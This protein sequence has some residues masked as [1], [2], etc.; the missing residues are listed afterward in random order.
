MKKTIFAMLVSL[1][2]TGCADNAPASQNDLELP[3][4]GSASA[5]IIAETGEISSEP[6][7][8]FDAHIGEM[9]DTISFTKDM[10]DY[11]V[12]VSIDVHEVI[13][14]D[15][16]QLIT[17]ENSVNIRD[18]NGTI[19]SSIS[20]SSPFIAG[21]PTTSRVSDYKAITVEVLELDSGNLLVI[22][23]PIEVDEKT[24]RGLAVFYFDDHFVNYIGTEKNRANFF[25][26]IDG[27]I[28]VD[29]DTFTLN[30]YVGS[31]REKRTV[32]YLVDFENILIKEI[33]E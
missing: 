9:I 33:T 27:D 29:G 6:F 23:T 24:A 19:A 14:S 13:G 7:W 30:E 20:F 32:T 17:D 18:K 16:Y 2:A 21:A 12:N 31:E 8:D 11:S 28:T 22:G 3:T 5:D 4:D 25:P 1:I 26:L 10:G 15:I